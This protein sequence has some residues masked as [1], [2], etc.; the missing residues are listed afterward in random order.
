MEKLM[1][2]SISK[3]HENNVDQ[4]AWFYRN[5]SC[6]INLISFFNKIKVIAEEQ[7]IE[8]SVTCLTWYCHNPRV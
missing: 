4:S 8:T 3:E 5:R 6:Q 1:Q 7:Y 2:Y